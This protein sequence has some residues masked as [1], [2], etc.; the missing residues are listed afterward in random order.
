MDED[1]KMELN[2]LELILELITG[3]S[4]V[5]EKSIFENMSLDQQM[6]ELRTGLMKS[7]GSD[8]LS[9]DLYKIQASKI[10]LESICEKLKNFQIS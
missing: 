3:S 10:A 9:N 4:L 6:L 8:I 1:D 5:P 2:F 7:R